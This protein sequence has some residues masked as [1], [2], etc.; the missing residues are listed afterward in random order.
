M[1]QDLSPVPQPNQGYIQQLGGLTASVSRH[2]ET[3]N[4]LKNVPA[5]L[6]SIAAALGMQVDNNSESQSLP[7][8]SNATQDDDNTSFIHEMINQGDQ[9]QNDPESNQAGPELNE[10]VL[11]ALADCEKDQ[12]LGPPVVK[13]VSD[14]INRTVQRAL[15]KETIADFTSKIKVPENCK[16]ILVPKI[17]PEIWSKLPTKAKMGDLNWQGIQQDASNALASLALSC[18]EISKLVSQKLIPANA[19]TR[20]LQI[21]MDAANMIGN[22][23]QKIN[24][25]RKTDIK[26][27]IHADYAGICSS[28]TPVTQYLFGDDL[29]ESLKN[30]KTEAIVM[31]QTVSYRGFRPRP[32]DTHRQRPSFGPSR[33]TGNLNSQRPSWRPPQQ[34]PGGNVYF[35]PQQPSFPNH[36]NRRRQ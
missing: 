19:A 5:M 7:D 27:H 17:N 1:S 20:L 26:P 8:D 4:G 30:S 15:S 34:R 6:S 13:A 25:K 9:A 32:Y 22:G 12:E 24:T 16:P 36:Q 3:L 21:N 33:S 28:S 18:N 11:K 23:F 14:A 31:R 29:K 35:R 10:A 2:E